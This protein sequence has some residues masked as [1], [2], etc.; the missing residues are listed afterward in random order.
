M[1]D[2]REVRPTDGGYSDSCT[3]GWRAY[4]ARDRIEA[5]DD[6]QDHIRGKRAK[7]QAWAAA[8]KERVRLLTEGQNWDLP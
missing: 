6:L 1:S 4:A 7:E 5:S 8:E 3:C 2:H